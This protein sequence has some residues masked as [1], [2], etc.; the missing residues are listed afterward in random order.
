MGPSAHVFF[1]RCPPDTTE[2]ASVGAARVLGFG[3]DAQMAAPPD[4]KPQGP[5]LRPGG[6]AG[7]TNSQGD[8]CRGSFLLV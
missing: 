6:I 5:A 7:A 1:H 3:E 2:V 8:R 4:V